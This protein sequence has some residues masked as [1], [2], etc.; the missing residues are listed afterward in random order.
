ME[1]VSCLHQMLRD[2][3][4]W[5]RFGVL[6]FDLSSRCALCRPDRA[7]CLRPLF[8]TQSDRRFMSFVPPPRSNCDPIDATQQHPLVRPSLT[9]A[10]TCHLSTNTWSTKECSLQ[11]RHLVR[12]T[13]CKVSQKGRV[14]TVALQLL[15][16]RA[17]V[18][19]RSGYPG[20]SAA[21]SK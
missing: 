4:R 3:D 18:L 17:L 11:P 8:F 10:L 5:T 13:L 7:A 12:C 21:R 16:P 9:L 15:D 14:F 20:G 1:A 6:C 2:G 19:N